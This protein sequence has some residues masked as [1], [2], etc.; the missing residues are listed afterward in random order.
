MPHAGALLRALARRPLVTAACATVLFSLAM[1]PVC[2]R[3]LAGTPSFVPAMLAVVTCFDVLSAYLLV[4][5]YRDRGDPRLLMMAWA[6]TWSLAVMAGYALAFPGAVRPDPPLAV[7]P[8]M[9]PYL[10]VAWHGGFPVLLGLAWAPW[11]TRWLAPTPVG[12]RT[13]VAALTVGAAGTAGAAVVAAFVA[14]GDRLPVLIHGLD[15]WRMTVVTAPVVLPLVVA[16]VA[17]TWRGVRRRTGPER[18]AFVAVLVCLCDLVLTYVSRPRDSLGWYTG[19]SLT[20]LSTGV[21]FLA[22]LAGFRRLK[23][24]AERDAAIDPLT[25]LANRR[26]AFPAAESMVARCHRSHGGLGVLGLDLDLFKQVNDRYG[27]EA[28]DRVLAEVGRLLTWTCRLGD[29]VA[30]VGGEEF[31]VL[32]PGTDEAGTRAIAER[33]RRTIGGMTVAGVDQRLT[34][35]VGASVWHPG[36]ASAAPLL[37]RVDDALYRAKNGG[38][39]RVVILAADVPDLSAAEPV[40][41]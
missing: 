19:R 23:A 12:R 15:T 24:Q 13:T 6:Y 16:A 37:R 18:W 35:S 32:L 9:A 41:P 21:V 11:P 39:D 1:L 27:H 2:G 34:I 31:L 30:R 25:G 33:I 17:V 7:T 20:L 3:Q 36:D 40:H 38:R 22:M 10:Y 14:A 28:G 5:D 29:V 4:G 26:A 8:S